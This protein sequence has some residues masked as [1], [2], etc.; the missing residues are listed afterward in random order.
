MRLPSILVSL[1]KLA[2]PAAV[3]ISS[4][5]L[6][7]I[8][9]W[10]LTKPARR[11]PVMML[12]FEGVFILRFRGYELYEQI[13]EAIRYAPPRP[14]FWSS[15]C[16][17]QAVAVLRRLHAEFG[18]TYVVTSEFARWLS[19]DEVMHLLSCCGL[20]FI[21]KSLHT[22]WLLPYQNSKEQALLTWERKHLR[23]GQALVVIDTPDSEWSL[24]GCLYSI[25]PH[26]VICYRADGISRANYLRARAI[27]NLQVSLSRALAK[28]ARILEELDEE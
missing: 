12:E 19:E 20:D 17:P 13:V 10:D 3:D 15:L 18:F 4:Q 14:D 24:G 11:P 8:R 28:S 21:Q 6:P 2:S 25:R 1:K 5:T 9:S 16:E 7:F 26:V 22:N 27:T 23:A